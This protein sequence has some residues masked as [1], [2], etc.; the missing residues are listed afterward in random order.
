M[1]LSIAHVCGVTMS[2]YTLDQ[3]GIEKDWT[4]QHKCMILQPYDHNQISSNEIHPIL[5]KYAF[6]SLLFSF[7]FNLFK[8]HKFVIQV[9]HLCPC[10]LQLHSQPTTWNCPLGCWMHLEKAMFR[11]ICCYNRHSKES[12][13]SMD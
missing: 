10:C 9:V 3:M 12:C 6:L 11:I 1:M 13:V 8:G 4:K 5:L 2:E 7:V